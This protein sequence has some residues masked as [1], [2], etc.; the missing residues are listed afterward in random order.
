LPIFY[1]NGIIGATRPTYQPFRIKSYQQLSRE[2]GILIAG[3]APHVEICTLT[4]ANAFRK[5]ERRM[6]SD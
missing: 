1:N 2:Y 3:I 5:I 4:I 6:R